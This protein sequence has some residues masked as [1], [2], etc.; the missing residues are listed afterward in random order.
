LV[1][2]IEFDLFYDYTCPFVYRAA[3]MLELVK[4]SGERQIDVTWRYFSLA[5]VNTREPSWTVWDGPDSESVRGRLAFR[6]AEA[7]RRQGAF[8]QLHMAL[9][10]ARHR[11]ASDIDDRRVIERLAAAAG[12]DLER[13]VHDLGD[14]DSLQALKRD[15]TAARST[16]GVF[17][18]PT[19]VFSGGEA[20]YIR[21]A[22]VP[23]AK[24]AVRVFG[25]IVSVAQGER[26]ILEIKRPVAPTAV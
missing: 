23:A 16:H 21:L 3:E 7:A 13:F 18:T 9:L 15:H 11:D 12:I 22:G 26:S 6:A 24:D 25:R 1:E 10:R 5:Q 20:A 19:F 8:D 17:G 14:P 4:A 2:S